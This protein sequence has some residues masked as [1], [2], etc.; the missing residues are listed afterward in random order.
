MSYG[1][2][3]TNNLG[4]IVISDTQFNPEY[5]GLATFQPLAGYNYWNYNTGSASFVA[6]TGAKTNFVTGGSGLSYCNAKYQIT[7]ATARGE[8]IPFIVQNSKVSWGASICSFQALGVSGSN[9]T[10]EILVNV[11]SGSSNDANG[12][13]D[14]MVFS[15]LPSNTIPTGVGVIVKNANSEISF[16]SNKKHLIPTHVLSYT[17]ATCVPINVGGGG[18][19]QYYCSYA[20][21]SQPITGLPA[22]PAFFYKNDIS[23][24]AYEYTYIGNA[25][26]INCV[27]GRIS[28]SNFESSVARRP[29]GSVRDLSYTMSRGNEPIIIIDAAKYL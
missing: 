28:G 12:M 21:I 13:P 24:F 19:T 6:G 14:I 29:F 22:S 17:S 5:V 8:P 25:Y 10:W 3:L 7:Y 4:E 27:V 9:T 16:D 15:K 11:V 23:D 26:T 18:A 2:E 20:P 1:F